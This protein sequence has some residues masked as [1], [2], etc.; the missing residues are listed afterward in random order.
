MKLFDL[1]IDGGC[2]ALFVSDLAGN[3]EY[4]F[5]CNAAHII[6]YAEIFKI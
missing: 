4:R 5:S 2:T 6:P 3:P 1:V